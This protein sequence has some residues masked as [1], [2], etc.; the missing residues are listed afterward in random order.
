M[1]SDNHDSRKGAR[2]RGKKLENGIKA[3]AAKR[4]TRER[5]PLSLISRFSSSSSLPF[6]NIWTE[7]QFEPAFSPLLFPKKTSTHFPPGVLI[8]RWAV[9]T[10]SPPQTP[11][12]ISRRRGKAGKQFFPDRTASQ[13]GWKRERGKKYFFIKFFPSLSTLPL[14]LRNRFNWTVRLPSG[15]FTNEWEIKLNKQP[16]EKGR[17]RKGFSR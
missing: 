4:E 5:T 8:N 9:L 1:K 16:E 15:H 3:A 13:E 6:Q 2:R 7:A 14:F 11:P 12:P 17:R 10:S